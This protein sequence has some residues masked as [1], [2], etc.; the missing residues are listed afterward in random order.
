MGVPGT[1]S[2]FR[3]LDH[4]HDITIPALIRR[5][6]G[7]HGGIFYFRALHYYRVDIFFIGN[8][9]NFTPFI[10]ALMTEFIL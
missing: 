6:Q 5:N 10:L 9:H 1:V 7:F 3:Q 8:D 2:A 4:P